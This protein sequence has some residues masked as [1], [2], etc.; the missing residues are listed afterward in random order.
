MLFDDPDEW[1][2]REAMKTLLTERYSRDEDCYGDVYA[3][4]ETPERA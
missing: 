1:I 2:S 3:Q 4:L